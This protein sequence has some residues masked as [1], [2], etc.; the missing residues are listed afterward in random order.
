MRSLLSMC[1][2]CLI[3]VIM[4]EMAT[5]KQKTFIKEVAGGKSLTDAAMVAYQP[6]DRHAA[7]VIGSRTLK[8]PSIQKLLNKMGLGEKEI[9][10]VLQETLRANKTMVING[11]PHSVPDYYTRLK[12][13]EIGLKLQ[14]HLT[15]RIATSHAPSEVK[16]QFIRV[17]TKGHQRV[18]NGV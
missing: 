3:G 9:V 16:V 4:A 15:E 10:K 13:A 7:S 6:K 11:T 14:G 1:W 8:A 12:T 5:T 18:L 2:Y 17:D